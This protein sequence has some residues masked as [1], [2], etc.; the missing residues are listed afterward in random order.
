MKNGGAGGG[1]FLNRIVAID[2][3]WLRSYEQELKS[4]STKWDSPASPRPA[5]FHRKQRNLKQLAT[6]A[7]DN[8]GLLTTD[9]VPVGET[10]NGEYYSIFLRKKIATSSA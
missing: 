3:T 5:K 8:S 6:F 1:T 4:Q 2:E 9:Y 7:Y 10:V